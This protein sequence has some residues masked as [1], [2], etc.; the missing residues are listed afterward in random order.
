MRAVLQDV[1]LTT[2]LEVY[3]EILLVLT[4]ALRY[5]TITAGLTARV[6]LST[7]LRTAA[8]SRLFSSARKACDLQLGDSPLTRWQI[9]HVTH[10]RVPD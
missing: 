4:K 7:S 3:C 1:Y 5:S 9:W 2:P 8:G 10:G 6:L